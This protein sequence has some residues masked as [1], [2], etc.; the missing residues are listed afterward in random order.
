L[1]RKTTRGDRAD[2]TETEDRDVHDE[3]ERVG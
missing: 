2:I 1:I 3:K